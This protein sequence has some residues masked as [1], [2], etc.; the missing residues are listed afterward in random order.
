MKKIKSIMS[1]LVSIL[2]VAAIAGCSAKDQLQSAVDDYN[3]QCPQDMGNGMEM[4][5][6]AIEDSQ[7]LYIVTID[8]QKLVPVSMLEGQKDTM[9]KSMESTIKG[10]PSI[11]KLAE[12]LIEANYPMTF[13]YQNK[14]ASSKFDVQFT[15]DELK[16]LIQ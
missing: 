8:E 6:V 2:L 9:K 15:V 7:L 14:D 5:K 11:K 12:L 3:K 4:T 16:T 10:N 1:M 13:R